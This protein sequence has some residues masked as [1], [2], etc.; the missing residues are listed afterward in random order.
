M[1]L[2][3]TT[4]PYTQ[5]GAGAAD[6]GGPDRSALL[7]SD[8][9]GALASGGR[10]GTPSAS[11][12]AEFYPGHPVSEQPVLLNAIAGA[13]KQVSSGAAAVPRGAVGT[14]MRWADG[15]LNSRAHDPGS[16]RALKP[17]SELETRW[18]RRI[19]WWWTGVF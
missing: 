11:E 4:P 10:V 9:D 14:C 12:A 8:V 16:R 13:F 6:P 19:D 2:D 17:Q 18:A 1:V 7:K 3:L 5:T 15:T